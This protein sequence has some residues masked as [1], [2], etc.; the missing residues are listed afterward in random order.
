MS[1]LFT[2]TKIMVEIA[3]EVA[4]IIFISMLFANGSFLIHTGICAVFFV[5]S[6]I[7]G[8]IRNEDQMLPGSGQHRYFMTFGHATVWAYFLGIL[9]LVTT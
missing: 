4:A 1:K 2:F 3:I 6:I 9:Y 7:F 5:V 8:V